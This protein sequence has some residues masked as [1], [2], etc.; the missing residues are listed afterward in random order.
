MGHVRHNQYMIRKTDG[1]NGMNLGEAIDTR[2]KTLYKLVDDAL[3]ESGQPVFSKS[4]GYIVQ[5]QSIY[6]RKNPFETIAESERDIY[7]WKEYSSEF[8]KIIL[9]MLR[10]K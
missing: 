6:A 1:F 3:K 5:E 10:G 2:K 9:R 4:K 7:I 8:S